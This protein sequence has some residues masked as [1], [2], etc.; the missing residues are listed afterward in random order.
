MTLG[1]VPSHFPVTVDVHGHRYGRFSDFESLNQFRHQVLT[2]ET[3][4]FLCWDNMCRVAATH[5]HHTQCFV[6]GNFCVNVENSLI[7]FPIDSIRRRC[8]ELLLGVISTLVCRML[9]FMLLVLHNMTR[10]LAL[11]RCD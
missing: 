1:V 4:L 2:S 5:L 6:V 8:W 9:S 7:Q 3:D 11:L 10:I